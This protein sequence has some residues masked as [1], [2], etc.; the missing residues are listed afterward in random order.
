MRFLLYILAVILL[1]SG[2]GLA[3]RAA[4]WIFRR[5]A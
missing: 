1:F 5:R 4:G 2:I 3:V